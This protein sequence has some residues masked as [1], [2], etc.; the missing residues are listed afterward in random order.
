MDQ[1]AIVSKRAR[2]IC[3]R[4]LALLSLGAATSVLAQQERSSPRASTGNLATQNRMDKDDTSQNESGCP[5]HPPSNDPLTILVLNNGRVLEGSIRPD[6]R[7]YHIQTSDSNRYFPFEYVK[8]AAR[9]L[10]DAYG[11]MCSGIVDRSMRRDVVLG[12]WCFENNLFPEAADHFR[13]VLKVDATNREARLCLA[14]I[15]ALQPSASQKEPG[16]ET[17]PRSQSN[18]HAA[19][20][21]PPESLERISRPAVREFL[22]GIQPILLSRCGSAKCHGNPDESV[23]R[24]EHVRMGSGANR[25]ATARNLE[26]VLK[27]LDPQF[28]SRSPLLATGFQVHGGS[29]QFAGQ[30]AAPAFQQARVQRWVQKVVPELNRLQREE[31]SRRFVN[32]VVQS[33]KNSVV[34]DGNVIPASASRSALSQSQPLTPANTWGMNNPTMGQTATGAKASASELGPLTDPFDPAEFNAGQQHQ[35]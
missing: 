8:I 1:G 30:G 16:A 19:E 32:D 12:R 18:R 27:Q 26:A 29:V 14:K 7:G 17:G 28:P 20:S 33:R 2:A 22:T 4:G 15:E 25:S 35:R 10:H 9:D 21:P 24:L 3:L 6:Q 23:L 34:R 11:K 5:S 13:N 31:S